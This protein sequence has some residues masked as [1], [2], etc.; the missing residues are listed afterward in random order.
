MA[1]TLS[2]LPI[3]AKVKDPG[4]KYYGKD[5]IFLKIAENHPGYPNNS[6]TLLSE[7]IIS[8]KASDAKEPNNSNSD[9]KNYGNNRYIHSNIK[10]WLNSSAS[11]WY[12]SKHSYD[13]P[14]TKDNL[15]SGH[16]PYDSEKGFMANLTPEL[17]AAILPT[18]LKVRK[19]PVDGGGVESF[20]D[21]IFLLSSTEVGLEND[22]SYDEGTKFDYFKNNSDRVAYPTKEAI[23]N[24]TYTR[25]SLSTSKGWY[26]WLRTPGSSSSNPEIVHYVSS[27]GSRNLDYAYNGDGGVRPALNLD[28]GILVSDKP[29]SDGAY[30]LIHNRPPEIPSGITV[31][32]TIRSNSKIKIS[33]TE[34]IDPDGDSVGYRLERKTDNGSF[35][36]VYEGTNKEY[37]DTILSS[38]NKIQYRIKAF[39]TYD[40]ESGYRTSPEREI[41][42]N[43][44]PVI[45]GQD[46]D[47]GIKT[48]PFSI[49]YTVTDEDK[50]V[51]VQEKING[52]TIKEFSVPLGKE[53][54]SKIEEEAWLSL[55]NGKH[56]HEIVATDAKGAVVSR[57]HTFTK[58]ITKSTVTLAKPLPADEMITK[59]IVSVVRNIPVGT[60]FKVEICNNAYD[61]NPT[62]EDVTQNVEM[63]SKFFFSNES[64]TAGKWGYNF[65]I[66]IERG[67]ADPKEEI[68][69]RSIGG[70]F[71]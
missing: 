51:K 68:Y 37:T 16:N 9:R 53:Q 3:G 54:T 39:D 56:T 23:D 20:T 48:G 46:T 28:S 58:K 36:Q 41:I 21:K 14:P 8:L 42:H 34:S 67:T 11:S 12:S 62:W 24:S 22:T 17:R 10:Q 52:K 1:K 4:S 69:I 7:R 15:W 59:T 32:G 44:P 43:I 66:E 38:W 65:R 30:T 25:D 45:S 6:T 2:S 35:R 64:N 49:K 50:E 27:Y 63:G 31:P 18:S 71:E 19:N 5:I 26:W 29:D 47:L 57:R 13:A 61:S 60:K 55:A 70:N 40:L 33:W